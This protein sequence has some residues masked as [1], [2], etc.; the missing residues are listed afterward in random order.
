[1]L[2]PICQ[3]LG[4]LSNPHSAIRAITLVF[5]TDLMS[6]GYT[7]PSVLNNSICLTSLNYSNDSKL[8]IIFLKYLMTLLDIEIS[9][10]SRRLINQL[11]IYHISHIACEN[12]C[13]T[14]K[15]IQSCSNPYMFPWDSILS[16]NASISP[17]DERLIDESGTEQRLAGPSIIDFDRD[18]DIPEVDEE[19]VNRHF[20][21]EGSTA[22]PQPS[23]HG[24]DE[25][26]STV[27]TMVH[28]LAAAFSKIGTKQDAL[29]FTGLSKV[30]KKLKLATGTQKS[31]LSTS[32]LKK[33][34]S[35]GIGFKL[36]S[37]GGQIDPHWIPPRLIHFEGVREFGTSTRALG[38]SCTRFVLSAYKTI[39]TD[40]NRSSELSQLT[41][42]ISR[43]M[44]LVTLQ[45]SSM[46]PVVV[47]EALGLIQAWVDQ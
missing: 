39:A 31:G 27:G 4:R 38:I 40:R 45:G 12:P 37:A 44:S 15:F 43:F 5:V 36:S 41:L 13:I 42:D 3:I 29:K 19:N 30:G 35:M 16:T 24:S 1:M 22:I 14:L 2:S 17:V 8:I 47:I 28:N 6:S 18:G 26:S 46:C 20:M 32:K 9:P 7:F 33:L 34:H 25:T 21:W 11:I 10:I 23:G